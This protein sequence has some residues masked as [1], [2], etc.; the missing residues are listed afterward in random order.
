MAADQ[1]GEARRE[2]GE[3]NA[4]LAARVAAHDFFRCDAEQFGHL[5]EVFAVIAHGD[6]DQFARGAFAG[7]EGQ[8]CD[9]RRERG[10]GDRRGLEAQQQSPCGRHDLRHAL[11]RLCLQRS[12]QGLRLRQVIQ[13]DQ[14]AVEADGQ[15]SH[16]GAPMKERIATPAPSSVARTWRAISTAPGL[17]P[18][19]QIESASMRTVEPS[20]AW[21]MPSRAKRSMR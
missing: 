9:A 19:T 10:E 8:G 6:G 1:I 2:T 21:T 3:G 13:L 14:H 7:R 18:C 20:R 16:H 4:V 5:G 11:K 12:Q 15:A 17:S